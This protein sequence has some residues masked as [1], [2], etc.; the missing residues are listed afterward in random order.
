MPLLVAGNT[1]AFELAAGGFWSYFAC[2]DAVANTVEVEAEADGAVYIGMCSIAALYI[3]ETVAGTS[4]RPLWASLTTEL[5]KSAHS[6]LRSA[7]RNFSA[8]DCSLGV[9][10]LTASRLATQESNRYLKS[11]MLNNI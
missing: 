3:A 10:A 8:C 1:A 4:D 7:C 2:L 5:Q 11:I 9:S 6:D